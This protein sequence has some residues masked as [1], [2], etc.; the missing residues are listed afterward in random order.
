M[1]LPYHLMLMIRQNLIA[2]SLF[3]TPTLSSVT[4]A[5]YDADEATRATIQLELD[6]GL[7]TTIQSFMIAQE[8]ILGY[9]RQGLL[10]SR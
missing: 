6:D 8:H 4:K 7:G 2:W 9:H 1:R 3:N 5:I 10:P